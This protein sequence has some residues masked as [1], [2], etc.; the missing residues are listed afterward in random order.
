MIEPMLIRSEMIYGPNR[1]KAFEKM[2]IAAR[3]NPVAIAMGGLVTDY[4]VKGDES[5]YG[6]TG[7]YWNKDISYTSCAAHA[8]FCD[9]TDFCNY[10]YRRDIGVRPALHFSK[11]EDLTNVVSGD[12]I[13]CGDRIKKNTFY[14]PN[15]VPD[16]KTQDNLMRLKNSGQLKEI[17][18]NRV[19]FIANSK[20]YCEPFT[21]KYC[22]YYEYE[23]DIYLLIDVNSC[24]DGKPVQFP[25]GKN[26]KDGDFIFLKVGKQEL[27]ADED[28]KEAYCRDEEYAGIP[29]SH[30]GEYPENLVDSDIV[31]YNALW[32]EEVEKLQQVVR[33]IKGKSQS[34]LE[35][36]SENTIQ[37][38]TDKQEKAQELADY[39]TQLRKESDSLGAEIQKL[40]AQRAQKEATNGKNQTSSQMNQGEAGD[41]R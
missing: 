22:S 23:G 1:S 21:P 33:E 36:N 29:F 32:W 26:Y 41:G 38:T 9:G 5:L 40:E 17:D 24:Y 18:Q 16:K 7:W 27:Y 3:V 2:G 35:I 15:Y 25:N 11:I 6:R 20:K 28:Y 19:K 13:D 31:K 39:F 4:H 30:T 37:A 10:V 8:V 34:N 12:W 14:Y